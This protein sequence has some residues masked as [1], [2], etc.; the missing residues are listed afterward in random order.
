MRGVPND[1][2]WLTRLRNNPPLT[3]IQSAS[4]SM[5]MIIE[6]TKEH[7]KTLMS[8]ESSGHD[9]RHTE[10]VL[11]LAVTIG[12]AEN[13]ELGVVQLAALL[14]DIADWKFHDGDESAGPRAAQAWLESQ[15]VDART[16]AHVCQ[17]IA[18][19]SRLEVS[20][21]RPDGGTE[22]LLALT[23]PPAAWP[24]PYLLKTP[25]LLGRGT[26]I[27]V[28]ARSTTGQPRSVRVRLSRYQ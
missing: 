10:R 20:A 23:D 7:V 12:R 9:W 25:R 28:F 24:T 13:A 2:N 18:D 11:K 26:E 21:R 5:E 16:I 3:I 8:G 19:L 22:I 15:G 27:F 1:T 6:R 14:H 17:I 4:T